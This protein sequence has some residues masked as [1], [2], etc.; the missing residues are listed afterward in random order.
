[1]KKQFRPETSETVLGS[2]LHGSVNDPQP[3]P[4]PSVCPHYWAQE[5]WLSEA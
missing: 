1:M 5:L 4:W 3:P 2:K